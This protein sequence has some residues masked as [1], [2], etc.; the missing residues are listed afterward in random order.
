[1]KKIV[2]TL[3]LVSALFA[4]IKMDV[5]QI[6]KMNIAIKP[7]LFSSSESF[8]PYAGSLDF[9]DAKSKSYLLSSEGSVVNAVKKAGE[10]VKKGEV[11]CRVSSVGLLSASF[12]LKEVRNK[13]GALENNAKKDE[14]LYKDGVI[15]YREY[16]KS[17]FEVAALRTK[18]GELNSVFAFAGASPSVNSDAS[19]AVRAARDGIL[20]IAPSRAGQKIEPF[21]PYLKI[22]DENA[23]TAY[24]KIPPKKI[25]LVKKGAVVTDKKGSKIGFIVSVSPSVDVSSNSSTAIAKISDTK[26]LLRAGASAE[27]FISSTKA[28]L[29]VML[30]LAS[31]TKYKNQDICFIRTKDGF[32]PKT[33]TVQREA[34]EGIFVKADGFAASTEVAVGGI[35]NLKGALSGMGFE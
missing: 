3:C 20:S 5:A 10:S 35:V 30:P 34:K 9:D 6:K 17:A 11:V 2:L 25:A 26:N 7:A 28:E 15:S 19:F 21:I 13:L 33:V 16:Q 27:F 12:E 22:S 32:A 18:L 1:M 23:L 24:I 14:A 29:S 31:V 8:G 4:D